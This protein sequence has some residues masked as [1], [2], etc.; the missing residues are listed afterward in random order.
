MQKVSQYDSS[1]IRVVCE[2]T[3]DFKK[4]ESRSD[5]CGIGVKDLRNR[6]I[7]N[8]YFTKS[9]V[10][11]VLRG[12]IRWEVET[13]KLKAVELVSRRRVGRGSHRST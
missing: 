6:T 12:P 11:E 4:I 13:R 3:K 5:S 2:S 8:V 7:I 1:R 9:S 10:K